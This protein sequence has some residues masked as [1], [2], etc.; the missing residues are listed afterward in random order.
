MAMYSTPE[1]YR[2]FLQNKLNPFERFHDLLSGK[3]DRQDYTNILLWHLI[4]AVAGINITAPGN[5]EPGSPVNICFPVMGTKQE[6]CM[7][8]IASVTTDEIRPQRMVDCRKA[9]RILLN[10]V[11]GFNQE[12]TVKVTGNITDSID[13]AKEIHAFNI[14]AGASGS[15]GFRFEE[16][17]PFV[18]CTVTPLVAPTQ[19]TVSA[20][21]IKQE[22]V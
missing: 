11:N 22:A 19:G 2:N 4:Q 6:E 1:E 7:T 20:S 15:Y 18:A 17:Q 8:G 12:V 9:N 13:S 16:W 3:D 14:A 10:V 5:N 21:V